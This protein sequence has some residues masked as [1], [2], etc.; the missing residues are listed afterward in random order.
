MLRRWMTSDRVNIPSIVRLSTHFNEKLISILDF[1]WQ[2]E[3][4]NLW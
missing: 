3:R 2:E 4:K 1:K